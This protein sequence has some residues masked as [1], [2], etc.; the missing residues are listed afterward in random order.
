MVKFLKRVIGVDE[1][2]RLNDHW[3]FITEKVV[4]FVL[5]ED[6]N[7]ISK[8]LKLIPD[9]VWS[10]SPHQLGEMKSNRT[11][12]LGRLADHNQGHQLKLPFLKILIF[13]KYL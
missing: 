12:R 4:E 7:K 13:F 9:R 8:F 10:K 6:S 2:E 5:T 1:S 11:Q 3:K